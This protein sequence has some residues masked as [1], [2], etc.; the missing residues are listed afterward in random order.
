[1][2]SEMSVFSKNDNKSLIVCFGGM[3]LK[4]GG[5]IPFEFLNYLKKNFANIADLIFLVD[6]NQYWYHK[7]ISGISKN[8][9]ETVLHINKRIKNRKYETVIFMGVSAGGYAALLFGSLCDNVTHVV[10]FIPRTLLIRYIDDKH[11]DIKYHIKNHIEYVL[12][13]E[14][15]TKNI[16]DN[17][18]IS[19]CERLNSHDNVTIVRKEFVDMKQMRDSGELTQIIKKILHL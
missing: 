11:K 4:M 1:M 7:G 8:I 17:H 6:R 13:G 15:S 16:N 5:I 2:S 18:H 19:Q 9:E 14:L 3:A 12:Y 10:S